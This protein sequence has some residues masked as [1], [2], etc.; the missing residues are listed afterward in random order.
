M[1]KN[2]IW[3]VGYP[4]CETHKYTQEKQSRYIRRFRF[5]GAAYTPLSLVFA[6]WHVSLRS[7]ELSSF[8][9]GH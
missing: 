6:G 3:M 8:R 5:L 7:L 4:H 2:P 1:V 9:T